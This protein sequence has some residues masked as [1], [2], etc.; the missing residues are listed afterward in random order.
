[1][2]P[3]SEAGLF[4]LII[5]DDEGHTTIVPLVK[6]EITIGRKEGNTIRLTERNVSRHHARLLKSNGTVFIEDLDSYNG[7]KVNGDKIAARTNVREGDLIEIGD[8]HFA[9]Q[10]IEEQIPPPTPSG[11]P[12]ISKPE[13]PPALPPA[14]DREDRAPIQ[15]YGPTAVLKLPLDDKTDERGRVRTIPENEAGRLVITSTD[16][17]GSEFPLTRSEML[18]GRTEENDIALAH[19]SISSRHAKIVYDGGIYRIIDMDSANGVLVNGEEYARV[20]LR[21]GDSIELGHV[22]I[23]YVAPGEVYQYASDQAAEMVSREIQT[24]VLDT[25]VVEERLEK[26][27]TGKKIGLITGSVALVALIAFGIYHF[28]QPGEDPGEE[29]AVVVTKSEPVPLVE[30]S[31]EDPAA[32]LF[33]E[34]EAKLGR[35][36]FKGAIIALN[37]ALKQN[38]KY[39]GG[40]TMIEKARAEEENSQLFSKVQTAIAKKDYDAAWKFIAEIPAD[41][42]FAQETEI[43]KPEVRTKYIS[44]H[45]NKAKQFMDNGLPDKALKHVESVFIVNEKNMYAINLRKEINRMVQVAKKPTKKP[46]AVATAEKPTTIRKKPPAPKLSRKKELTKLLDEGKKAVRAKRYADAV[47]AFRAALKIEPRNCGVLVSIG[48]L[49]ARWG[50]REKSYVYYKKFLEYCP[51]HMQA[52]QVRQIVQQFENWKRQNR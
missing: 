49:Y 26:P 11:A 17:G 6:E 28:T 30:P 36:D 10:W 7:V 9:L 19:R 21:R 39:P 47:S 8:Y 3:F 31:R 51:K 14:Q 25:L 42:V 1:V 22:R 38:P 32:P 50:K 45:L 13:S 15:A 20:D 12:P 23:R 5:E 37:A 43:I 24:E 52:P 34:G 16:L 46:A 48:I 41:S 27:A 2:S 33:K 4:K 40:R 35:H 29:P 44:F 18:I